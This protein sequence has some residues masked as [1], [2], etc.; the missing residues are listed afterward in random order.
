MKFTKT[1]LENG[2]RIITVPQPGNLAATILV[3]VEAGSEYETKEINGLSHFLEH[4][5]FKGT[6]KRPRSIDISA[7]L[8]SIGAVYNAFTGHQYTGYFAK[9][10]KKHFNKILDVVSD[11]YLNPIFELEEI[12]KERGVI[13]EEINMDEDLPMR[14]IHDLF[15]ELLYGDQPAGWDVAG[16]K[17]VIR[18]LKRDDFI[19]YRQMNYLAPATIIVA[20]G[21]IDEA[22]SIGMIKTAFAE[23]PT[24]PKSPRAKVEEKQEKPG[25][26]L[27]SKGT[28]QTHLLLGF[29]AFDI[30]DP[31]R[32]SLTV[33]ADILGGGMSSRLF[34]R[35]RGQMGAAYYVGADPSLYIDHGYLAARAGVDQQRTK[36]VIQAI[37]EEF[38]RFKNE[39]VPES[40]LQR[41][42]D[43]LVGHLML[44]LETSDALADFYGEQE[45]MTKEIIE[46]DELARRIQAVKTEEIQAVAAELF[47]DNKLN[48][49][50]IGPVKEEGELRNI[51]KL[52]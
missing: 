51:L 12:E 29:R 9:A 28:D 33:L 44:S 8:D 21:A 1:I 20:A 2:L 30:F 34:Q 17:Q 23:I 27:S 11:M 37:L 10:D 3:L 22:K 39:I 24:G 45:I 42:K 14:K 40:E 38:E 41:A 47:Q 13:I 31:R 48:L 15:P 50:I 25:L 18:E 5:C 46:P 49:A 32:Y 35:I 36:E 52:S 16:R 43:H 4:L 26:L 6:K 7:E 19:N